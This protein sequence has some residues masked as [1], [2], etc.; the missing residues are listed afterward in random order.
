PQLTASS[1]R[2]QLR[3]SVLS[4][5]G[6]V[7]VIESGE[8]SIDV[9]APTVTLHMPDEKL[10]EGEPFVFTATV[11]E[12]LGP[13]SV[14]LHVGAEGDER[15]LTMEP[16][17]EGVWSVMYTPGPE[18]ERAWVTVDDGVHQAESSVHAMEVTKSS[19]SGGA[20]TSSL[21]V[22][23]LAAT[24]VA[25]ILTVVIVTLVARRKG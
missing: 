18:D 3:L 17:G 24:G 13:V 22:E 4:W 2:C 23:M 25:I 21:M 11:E 6:D 12:D 8:F 7:S 9:N 5:L 15:Q 1:D 20:G 14:V 16:E 10:V 19:A